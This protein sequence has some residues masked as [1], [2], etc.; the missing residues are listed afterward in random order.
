VKKFF[1]RG[2][3]NNRDQHRLHNTDLKALKKSLTLGSTAT[4]ES[5]VTPGTSL[6][7]TKAREDFLGFQCQ[8]LDPHM[9]ASYPCRT[10][11]QT[12]NQP[13]FLHN[14]EIPAQTTK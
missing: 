1:F 9:V 7:E 3:L 14:L 13:K 6:L 10:Q 4:L 5:D 11:P 8:A 12:N 2:Q